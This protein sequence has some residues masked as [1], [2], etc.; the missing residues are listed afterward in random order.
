MLDFLGG[1]FKFAFGLGV[2]GFGLYLI[3]PPPNPRPR[4]GPEWTAETSEIADPDARRRQTREYVAQDPPGYTR[5]DGAPAGRHADLAELKRRRDDA[6][7]RYVAA[8]ESGTP[9]VIRD[10]EARWR[11]AAAEY[12]AAR[13]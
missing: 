7:A 5:A 1:L 6:Y 11:K 2:L 3:A 13:R 9:D 12:D 4:R 8:L 10:A